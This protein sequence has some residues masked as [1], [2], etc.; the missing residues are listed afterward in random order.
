MCYIRTVYLH[1]RNFFTSLIFVA[2]WTNKNL[3]TPNFSQFMVLVW[4]YSLPLFLL[5]IWI[6][7][8]YLNCNYCHKKVLLVI[9]VHFFHILLPPGYHPSSTPKKQI[10][11]LLVVGAG[12]CCPV[13]WQLPF[14]YVV[15]GRLVTIVTTLPCQVWLSVL[16]SCL[17]GISVRWKATDLLHD[18]IQARRN[19]YAKKLYT[20]LTSSIINTYWHKRPLRF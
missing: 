1:C 12:D 14:C 9:V 18:T 15:D 10:A 11:A 3:L 5:A 7:S 8:L 2:S 16:S 6:W 20:G 13:G 17:L 19:L 4:N